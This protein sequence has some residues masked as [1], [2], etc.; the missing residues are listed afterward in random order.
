M[1][2]QIKKINNDIPLKHI[3]I[4]QSLKCRQNDHKKLNICR[5]L[6]HKYIYCVFIY[7]GTFTVAHTQAP[8]HF[9]MSNSRGTPSRVPK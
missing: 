4:N 3:R 7:T 6:P 9:I 1:S 2:I 5:N 8:T